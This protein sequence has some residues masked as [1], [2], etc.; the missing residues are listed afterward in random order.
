MIYGRVFTNG[1]VDLENTRELKLDFN[2][3]AQT[4][5][6]YSKNLKIVYPWNNYNVGTS[7]DKKFV[8]ADLF[9]VYS[10]DSTRNTFNEASY[11]AYIS[12][13]AVL[14]NPF[15]SFNH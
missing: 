9:L 11:L 3:I 10:P 2:G 6:A 8:M 1:R 15:S 4:I 7:V 12:Q 13:G 14:F 5:A